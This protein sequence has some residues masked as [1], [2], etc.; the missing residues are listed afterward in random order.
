MCCVCDRV[1][2]ARVTAWP[3]VHAQRIVDVKV[4]VDERDGV[5]ELRFHISYRRRSH[6]VP[7][8]CFE[9]E[10]HCFGSFH[11]TT[12]FFEVFGALR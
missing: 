11:V 7:L 9:E 10:E 4:R 6:L 8:S 2:W 1:V 12:R 3:T 5:I